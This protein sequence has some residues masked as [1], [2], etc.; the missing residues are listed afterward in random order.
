MLDLFTTVFYVFL[1]HF[2]TIRLPGVQRQEDCK[3]GPG[4]THETQQSFKS[5]SV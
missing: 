3:C 4:D 1:L 5:Q 2:I